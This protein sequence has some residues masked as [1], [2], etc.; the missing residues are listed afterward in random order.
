MQAGTGDG[1]ARPDGSGEQDVIALDR[2]LA[3][4]E[5]AIYLL[6][7]EMP[8]ALAGL[9][10]RARALSAPVPL[11]RALCLQ[12]RFLAAR[13]DS[14]AAASLAD[15]AIAAFTE[16]DPAEVPACA[17]FI[18]E[19]WRAACVARMGSARNAE[20]LR[21]I[22]QA[23]VLAEDGAR[24]PPDPRFDDTPICASTA[25]IRARSTLA[26]ILL[27]ARDLQGALDI[28]DGAVA[29][30]DAA[31]EKAALIPDDVLLVF[32]NITETL[33]RLVREERASGELEAAARHLEETRAILD[34]RLK[35]MVLP[36]AAGA[37]AAPET[38][39]RSL[40]IYWEQM[41]ENLLL[42]ENPSEALAC[43]LKSHDI[44]LTTGMS[45]LDT[46]TASTGIAQAY[47]A[48]GERE[49]ALVHARQAVEDIAEENPY[50]R[51]V[52]LLVLS[53][54]WRAA[55]DF[56]QA[57]DCFELSN[58]LRNRLEAA[59]TRQYAAR[60]TARIGLERAQAEAAAERRNT[61]TLEALGQIGQQIIANLEAEI[62]FETLYRH[63]GKLLDAPVFIIWLLDEAA[64][65]LR[66]AFGFEDGKPV[67]GQEIAVDDPVS[68]AARAVRERREILAEDHPGKEKNAPLPGTRRMQATL[69]APLLLADRCLGVLSVQSDRP[70]AYDRTARWIL[71]TLCAYAA[72]ALDNAAAHQQLSEALA[73]LHNSQAQLARRTEELE[74]LSTIDPLTGAGNRRYL[75]SKA[76]A[77]IAA[78]QRQSRPLGVVLFDIDHFKTINDRFGH[79]AGDDVLK[80]IVDTARRMLRPSDFLARLGG[81][82]FALLLPGS[83]RSEAAVIAER[84]RI[85]F[86]AMM[87]AA[88][89]IGFTVTA[90]FGTS[91]LEPGESNLSAALNRAD[92]AL[93]RA[94]QSGRN[95]AVAYSR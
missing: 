35:P 5:A 57:L 73:E 14:I 42:Q 84:I 85:A 20:A 15:A 68:R 72:I 81:E 51:S 40:G 49:Q 69:F 93:Y 66:L 47:L 91:E 83:D 52:A 53:R 55:G 75:E 24:H 34:T 56:R 65:C 46:G 64:Q 95:R 7:P 22:N 63:V 70:Q 6:P 21:L 4:L 23:I 44:M 86:E 25:L 79:A 28:L 36:E 38:F 27:A 61:A 87:F 12:A 82:E 76:I 31:P 43:F 39:G 89:S 58:R 30:I 2:E 48:L 94:K 60:I 29:A 19:A 8:E 62:I 90:S 71:R 9:V 50:Y 37:A 33:H 10:A 59:A 80:D 32:G 1:Q 17:G 45:R 92:K 41:G 78:A 67:S 88:G 77:E 3:Q 74:R 13:G 11:G 18:A 26:V 16:I 54:A